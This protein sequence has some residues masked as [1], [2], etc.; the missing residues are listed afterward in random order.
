M[1]YSLKAD[2]V[3]HDVLT[4]AKESYEAEGYCIVDNVY[5]PTELDVMDTFF[6]DFK[7]QDNKSFGDQIC[8]YDS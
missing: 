6:E 8:T 1:T 7:T 4:V 3:D 5:P 2:C